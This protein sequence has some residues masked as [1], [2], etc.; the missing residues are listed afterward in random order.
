MGLSFAATGRSSGPRRTREASSASRYGVYTS[1][2]DL[3]AMHAAARGSGSLQRHP[4]EGLLPSRL[5]RD[6]DRA[7][8]WSGLSRSTLAA[9]RASADEAARP[10]LIVV[11][12][13]LNMFCGSRRSM[14]SVAAAEAAALCAWRTLDRRAAV[15]GVVFGDAIIEMVEPDRG[16]SAPMRL[17]EAIASQ[18]ASLRAHSSQPRAPSQLDAALRAAAGLARQ[19][20]LVVVVSDFH[21]RGP[22]T[23]EILIRLAAR[24][25]VLAILVY[26]PYLL[27][28]PKTGDIVVSGGELQ[29]D[30]DFGG[31]RIRRSLFEFAETCGKEILAFERE[32]GVPVLALSAAEETAPQLRG[33]LDRR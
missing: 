30:L 5:R 17:I 33:L 22:R 14:K 21:G 32:I 27:D 23:R 9:E 4:V 3:V 11:D 12:Q 8:E 16:G 1:V 26:D 31:G 25:D 28:L 13:R 10:A 19:D 29:V 2:A 20:H 18:N 15:G 7:V 24:N 6:D